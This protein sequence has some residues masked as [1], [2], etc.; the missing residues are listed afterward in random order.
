MTGVCKF[1]GATKR[2]VKAHIVP[3]GFYRRVQRGAHALKVLTNTPGVYPRKSPVGEYDD[4][5]LCQECENK[6]GLWDDYAQRLITEE[7]LKA[8]ELRKA[9]QIVGYR[10]E[11]YDYK[12]LKLFFLSVAWRASVSNR[13]FFKRVHLGYH[14]HRILEMLKA[15]DPGSTTE[16]GVSLAYFTDQYGDVFLDPHPER[17]DGV[18]YLRIYLGGLVAYVKVDQ[19]GAPWLHKPLL[20]ASD[21]PL[22]IV[23][24]TIAKSKEFS[25]MKRIVRGNG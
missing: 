7:S 9:G 2:L 8:A 5:I 15:N 20:M 18:N 13:A 22:H 14:E 11:E 23:G 17:W 24:R 16:Y 25:L 6:F 19:R 10:F 1:C 4:G 21:K 3:E 12:L